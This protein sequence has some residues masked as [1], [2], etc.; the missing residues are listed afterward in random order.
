MWPEEEIYSSSDGGE[1]WQAAD[2]EDVPSHVPADLQT[3]R[4]LPRV[5]CSSRDPNQ[6]Y[7]VSGTEVVE[8]SEDSGATW[9]AAWSIPPGRR[10][11][12]VRY[13][14]GGPFEIR[15]CGGGLNM[16]PYDVV[17]LDGEGGH[18]VLV[19]MG[20]D[21]LLRR[22]E[23][24]NWSRMG[25]GEAQPTPYHGTSLAL[26]WGEIFLL[27]VLALLALGGFTLW[28]RLPLVKAFQSAASGGLDRR[29]VDQPGCAVLTFVP[30]VA[31]CLSLLFLVNQSSP[32]P[33]LALIA[34][35]IMSPGVLI[36][37]L[38]L[39][40]K[41]LAAHS[42]DAKGLRRARD[43]VLVACAGAFTLGVAPFALWL[44]A[45]VP[46]YGLALSASVLAFAVC[47]G[48]GVRATS[49]TVR[50]QRQAAVSAEQPGQIGSLR[51]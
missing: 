22:D 20:G 35:A 43:A 17:V 46:Q 19:A 26:V 10:D 16:G 33:G 49:A 6:C 21:G 45:V 1:S 14:G 51:G 24:G 37:G 2:L 42:P 34:W 3:W 28:V 40:W 41:Q 18:V 11:F 32:L 31:L 50:R 23:Q 7:R 38:L 9:A 36:L 30:I 48:L 12:M 39:I 8:T 4:D 13:R 5:A 29:Q 25:L 44:R 15:I 27:G 47:L